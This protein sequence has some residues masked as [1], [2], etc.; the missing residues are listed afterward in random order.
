MPDRI[1]GAKRSWDHSYFSDGPSYDFALVS[2]HSLDFFLRIGQN[3]KP[4]DRPGRNEG[5]VVE[6]K[7]TRFVEADDIRS[8]KELRPIFHQGAPLLEFLPALVGCRCL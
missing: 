8:R 2:V 6:D 3:Q 4:A 1:F 5:R 7:S